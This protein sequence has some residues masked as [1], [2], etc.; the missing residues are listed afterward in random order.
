MHHQQLRIATLT[1]ALIFGAGCSAH[2]RSLPPPKTTSERVVNKNYELGQPSSA[3][4]GDPMIRVKD[5]VVTTSEAPVMKP[6][7]SVV[8]TG[9]FVRIDISA[10]DELEI[11]GQTE[12]NG[13][14][15]LVLDVPRAPY[16]V[17]V[18]NSGKPTGTVLTDN[19]GQNV[20]MV[21][22]FDINP[23]NT[24]FTRKTAESITSKAAF[25]NFEIIYTGKSDRALTLVYREYTPDDM[26][27]PAFTQNLTYDADAKSI[28]FKSMKIDVISA[29]NERIE[30][31]VA[32]E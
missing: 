29:T 28:R 30:F 10:E 20:I 4:I 23:P 9:G 8:L 7:S 12:M 3:Y 22:N 6:S 31:R 21:Y 16:Q 17:L 14:T 27:R 1:A 19:N 15:L 2:I 11:V 18:T 13:Q 26:A 32:A 24:V 25:T 5:Y